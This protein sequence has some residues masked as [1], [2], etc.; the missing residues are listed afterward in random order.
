MTVTYV[1]P[2]V[3]RHLVVRHTNYDAIMNV[4][5][6]ALQKNSANTHTCAH[7]HTHTRDPEREMNCKELGY[8]IKDC[9]NSQTLRSGLSKMEN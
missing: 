5:I 1:P 7:I 9:K 8:M 4:F 3:Q 6:R 2:V